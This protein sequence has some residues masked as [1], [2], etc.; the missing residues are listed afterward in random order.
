M[1]ILL[2]GQRGD[3]SHDLWLYNGLDCM[4]TREVWD[5]IAPK[6]TGPAKLVY[7]FEFGM[8]GPALDMMLRGLNV[9]HT[10]RA[11]VINDLTEQYLKLDKILQRLAHAVWERELNPQ[12]PKQ[13]QAF[14]YETMKLPP[15]MVYDKKTRERRPTTN[16]EALEKLQAYFF[17]APVC[18]TILALRDVADKLS[19]LRSGLD[20]DG[21]LRCSYNVTGT[22]TGRWSSSSSVFTTGTNLNNITDKLRRV[23]IPDPPKKFCQIDLPQAESRV[24]AFLSKDAAYQAACD[25]GDLHTYCAKL[26][27]PEL[28]WP[29]DLR[30]AREL[31]EL[32]F[33]RWFTRR[34]MSKRGG[35]LTNYLGTDMMMAMHLKLPKQVC[36]DFQAVYHRTFPGIGAWHRKTITKIQSDREMTTLMGR[37]RQFLGRPDDRNTWKEAIAHEPQSVIGDL[38]NIGLWRLWRAGYEICTQVYDSIL[39][40]YD[41]EHE[42]EVIEQAVALSTVKIIDSE[43]RELVLSAEP[44]VGWNWGKQK[45]LKSGGFEN[46]HGL[47]DWSP[48]RPDTRRPP[49]RAATEAGHPQL[50]RSLQSCY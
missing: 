18:R 36:A 33:Y 35:H 46:E 31:A 49:K 12:S 16:R 21:R 25:S 23:I 40:Q 32:P 14:F 27:W 48:S 26:L 3:A 7:D 2:P 44:A 30:A 38:L 4:V 29:P 10:A 45:K 15:V 50:A 47:A 6:L 43:G 39:F 42:R 5:R 22:E 34:D 1:K 28:P 24:V 20:P 41:P 9:E 19:V 8:Q 13:L 11:E 37:R 17:A